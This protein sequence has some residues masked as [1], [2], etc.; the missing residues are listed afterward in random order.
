MNLQLQIYFEAT[1]SRKAAC[2]TSS[3]KVRPSL[4]QLTR[5]TWLLVS[6]NPLR[7]LKTDKPGSEC[8]LVGVQPRDVRRRLDFRGQRFELFI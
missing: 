8:Q 2:Y 1:E 5:S 6:V 7:T 4:F 3:A